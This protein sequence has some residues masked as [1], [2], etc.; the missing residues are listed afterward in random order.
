MKNKNH[1]L[2]NLKREKLRNH[3]K[4]VANDLRMIPSFLVKY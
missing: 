3:S 1:P 2:K 4:V